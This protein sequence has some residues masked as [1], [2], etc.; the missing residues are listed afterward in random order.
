LDEAMNFTGDDYW[1][2]IVL[3]GQNAASYKIALA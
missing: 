3:F 2:A 1:K